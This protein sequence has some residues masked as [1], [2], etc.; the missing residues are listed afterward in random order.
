MEGREMEK[1]EKEAAGGP[2]KPAERGREPGTGRRYGEALKRQVVEQIEAG[3]LTVSQAQRQHGIAGTQTI[4]A[5]QSKY[6]KA[7]GGMRKAGALAVAQAQIE[8]LKR[9][10]AEL[11]HAISRLTVKSV[12]LECAMEEAEV[13]YGED[14]KKK[15]A[16]VLSSIRASGSGRKG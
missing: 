2:K 7:G 12:V 3:K 11:E 15:F 8:K 10:K 13:Q 5:W 1:A 14:F 4:R 9:E 6:G 16:P